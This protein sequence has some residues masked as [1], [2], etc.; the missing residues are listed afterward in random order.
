MPILVVI[1]AIFAAL[2]F[3]TIIFGA[4]IGGGAAAYSSIKKGDEWYETALKPIFD[5]LDPS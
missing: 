5:L 4:L 1:F 3:G 2:F